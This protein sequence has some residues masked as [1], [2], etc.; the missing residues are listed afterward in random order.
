MGQWEGTDLTSQVSRHHMRLSKPKDFSSLP[1][2]EFYDYG[3][4]E[5]SH[6][7]HKQVVPRAGCWKNTFVYYMILSMPFFFLHNLLLFC[8]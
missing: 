3:K 5:H 7:Y 6:K 8:N 2:L 4:E 1:V